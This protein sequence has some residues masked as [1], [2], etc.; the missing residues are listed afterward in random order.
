[1]SGNS[2]DRR[3][4]Q[5][6]VQRVASEQHHGRE[7]LVAFV[8]VAGEYAGIR[9]GIGWLAWLAAGFLWLAAVSYMSTALASSRFKF[10]AQAVA[11]III[12]AATYH[13][14]TP[15]AEFP[16]ISIS[17]QQ[18]A[19]FKPGYNY[20]YANVFFQNIGGPGQIVG[21]SYGA[22]ALATTEP[23]EVKKDLDKM[24][25]GLVS[26]DKK[27]ETNVFSLRPQDRRWL[28]V[29]GPVPSEEQAEGLK[30][31]K[32]AFYF[33]GVVVVHGGP[34]NYDF[35]SFVEGNKPDVILQCPD[36]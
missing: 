16:I 21:Y 22:I 27:D 12:A 6:A 23:V 24:L 9:Y 4:F 20:P 30:S 1:M 26:Q 2:Q 17:G 10:P 35:C 34:T 7:Y 36:Q 19:L 13:L 11:A 3:T 18:V 25:K 32:Y 14:V 28:T 29:V 15:P 31:G 5:R 8:S 33:S